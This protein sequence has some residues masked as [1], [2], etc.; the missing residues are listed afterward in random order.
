MAIMNPP[1]IAFGFV[2]TARMVCSVIRRCRP[3]RC[4]ASASMNPPMNRKMRSFAYGAAASSIPSTPVMGKSISGSRAVAASGSASVTH[5]TAMSR[6][7]ATVARPPSDSPPSPVGRTRKTRTARIGP[8][9][10][11]SHVGG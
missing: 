2:P 9:N 4:I 7:I 3:Q 8:V 11:P 6:P 10:L 5:Q 1:I